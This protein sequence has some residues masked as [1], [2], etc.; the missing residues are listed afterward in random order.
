MLLWGTFW[1]SGRRK[2]PSE[3]G[4]REFSELSWSG[5]KVSEGNGCVREPALLRFRGHLKSSNTQELGPGETRTFWG[6]F[7]GKGNSKAE[8]WMC[9]DLLRVLFRE[10]G[11]QKIGINWHGTR[12]TLVEVLARSSAGQCRQ[13][14][15]W[16]H[17]ASEPGALVLEIPAM[18]L[19]STGM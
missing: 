8:T 9:A 13:V 12:L 4:G 14:G 5:R 1:L 15:R 11:S 17:S 18:Q 7:S 3:G 19:A 10:G 6:A 2:R 16:F